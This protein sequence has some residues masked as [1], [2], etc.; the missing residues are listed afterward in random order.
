MPSEYNWLRREPMSSGRTEI[1]SSA[2]LMPS[3]FG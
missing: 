1:P 2:A 3:S